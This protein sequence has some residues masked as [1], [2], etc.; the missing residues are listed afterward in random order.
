MRF[1]TRGA[2]WALG[3]GWVGGALAQSD[4]CSL[5]SAAGFDFEV[6]PVE[7]FT[8]YWSVD[9]DA[10]EITIETVYSGRGYVG[11][12]FS[13][14]GQ[15][16]PGDAVVGLPD[17]D[18][19]L[20]YDMTGY[21]LVDVTENANQEVTGGV[22]TQ[23]GRTTTL[24]FTRPLAPTDTSKTVLSSEEGDTTYL[25]WAHGFSNELAYHGDTRGTVL[26]SDLNCTTELSVEVDDDEVEDVD[27]TSSDPEYEFEIAPSGDPDELALFWTVNGSSV[28]VKAV[29][30]GEGWLGIGFSETGN[31]PGSDAVIGLPDDA[32]ALEY[33]MD[34]YSTPVESAQQELLD[35]T[36]TQED[37]VTTLTFVRLLEPT[38]DG[39]LLLD[40]STPANWLYAWGA[41]N[42]FV[43][44]SVDG[45]FSLAL[46]SCSDDDDDEDDEDAVDEGGTTAE[47]QDV[48]CTSSDPD[49]DFEVA[50]SGN[51]DEL[52]LFWTVVGS[53]VA[54]KAVY[55]GEGWLGI[56]FS[57]SGNM[58]GSDAVIGLPDELTALEYDMDDYNTPV[59]SA[60]QELLD[61]TITQED[62][63]T[64][65][66]F[67][68]P[69]EPT[70]DGKL[71]LDES[72]P[73]NWLYAWGGSNDFVRHSVDGAFSLTLNS[74]SVGAAGGGGTTEEYTHGWLMVLGWTLCFPSGIMFA[75]FS[76]SFKDLGFPAH[77]ILQTLGSVLV[78]AGF[79]TAIV[80]TED[81][82]LDHFTTSHGIAGLLLTIFVMLQVVA[83]VFRPSK[84]PAG[85]VVQD[86]HGHTKPQPPSLVRRAW[87]FLHKGLGY[88]TVVW[89]VV[90]CFGGLDQAD[91]EDVW[92]VL[93]FLLVIAMI[94]AFVV[95][96]TLACCRARRN[97][98]MDYS[99]PQQDA[100][101]PAHT[102]TQ[103]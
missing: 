57:D 53:S 21:F 33:D 24:T 63:V 90:Q 55:Q 103:M 69:L 87:T 39:K 59:E 13:S 91:A 6:T 35:A 62:G 52:A 54:V 58:P 43:K 16:V 34:S 8:I 22:V 101:A 86:E 28:A 4:E 99:R 19:V 56:G 78:I 81:K 65:L 96:Q 10:Q 74:C 94:T 66:T 92:G 84:P 51:S 31:M 9:A 50:P 15:M 97:S 89:A 47:D 67:V 12:G 29:Y 40:V 23:V 100:G 3:A 102:G 14:D 88:I 30:Q 77:R 75:R 64:T 73:A 76:N 44:H 17:D 32:T 60:E 41:S 18:T 25:L 20:E 70:G 83:A 45:S 98:P 82:G 95:L 61:A 80:F 71:L 36:I 93:Y 7:G 38:G 46:D 5:S 85:A 72:T 68:R 2:L 37:G 11:I 1:G 79:I 27:C 26:L 42:D 48:D 49:Y